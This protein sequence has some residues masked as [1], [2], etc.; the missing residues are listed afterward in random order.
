MLP[1]EP[2]ARNALRDW[3]LYSSTFF[4]LDDVD[5]CAR[6]KLAELMILRKL[7]NAGGASLTLACSA[8]L[9]REQTA[10]GRPR[11][12]PVQTLGVCALMLC[13]ALDAGAQG[14]PAKPVRIVVGYPPGGTNDILARLLAPRL[15]EQVGQTV[16]VDN[17]AG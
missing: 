5:A 11:L 6:R 8:D 2:T 15:T 3:R 9:M 12:I 16:I 1:V 4:M 17:R 10:P 14:Y 13:A 7:A